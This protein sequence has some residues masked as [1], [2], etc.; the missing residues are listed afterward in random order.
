MF[1][2]RILWPQGPKNVNL[3]QK[4]NLK[5]KI[6]LSTDKNQFWHQKGPKVL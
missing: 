4:L 6:G 1:N 2:E 5:Y 3:S